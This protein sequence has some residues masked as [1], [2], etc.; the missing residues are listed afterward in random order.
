MKGIHL[1]ATT[2]ICSLLV[3][4]IIGAS[5]IRL[6][7]LALCII[8]LCAGAAFSVVAREQ[9]TIIT[10]IN[11]IFLIITVTITNLAQRILDVTSTRPG[12]SGPSELFYVRIIPLEL[13]V[14]FISLMAPTIISHKEEFDHRETVLAAMCIIGIYLLVVAVM[15]LIVNPQLFST[16]ELIV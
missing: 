2:A 5:L 1:I 7:L 8:F 10:I 11:S 16:T 14:L 12:F 6:P 13:A 3:V 4:T 15:S 9:V